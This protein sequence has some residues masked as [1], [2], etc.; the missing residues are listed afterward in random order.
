LTGLPQ[1]IAQAARTGKTRYSAG[2]RELVRKNRGFFLFATLAAMA[3]RLLFIL[4]TPAITADSFVYGD[5]AKNW[6][7]HGIYGLSGVARISP[8]DIRLPGYPAF[9]ALVFRIFGMEHY[10]AALILQMVIDITTCFIIADLACRLLS[11]RAAKAAFLLSALCPFLA[12]YAG[13][14]LTETWEVFFTALALNLAIAG[15]EG[16]GWF[17]WLAAGLACAGAILMRPDG[18]LLPIAMEVYLAALILGRLRSRLPSETG[19][20]T[21][22]SLVRAGLVLGI[23]A[24]LPLVPWTVRNWRTFEVFQPLAPRYANE[25]NAFVP[26]GFERW[27]KTWI[28]D[29]VS[30]E[31]VYWAVPGSPIEAKNLPARAFDSAEQQQ[32]TEHLLDDYNERRQIDPVLDRRFEQLAEQRIRQ[33]HWRYWV[34]LPLLR[35]A[36]MWL[37][38]R[39][40]IL[41]CNSRWWEFDEEPLWLSVTIVLGILNLLYLGA[42]VL[43]LVRGSRVL[44]L[45][46]LVSFLILRSAFLG[47]LENPETRYTLEG[48]PVV[49]LLAAAAWGNRNSSQRI[50]QPGCRA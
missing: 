48:Y 2:V 38:P 16:S 17:R 35:I 40:E 49:I 5:I 26:L 27:M 32:E 10:R 6:L 14:A 31:E 24:L 30:T 7:E 45:G 25:A 44:H 33:D 29:Y 21:I 20:A 43:G 22:T 46:L 3:L 50:A 4:R 1:Q 12:N 18:I 8:T 15:L 19:R 47:T 42:A 11:S 34:W 28:A 23:S 39:T 9:L 41:P 37:R 13:A 36:G